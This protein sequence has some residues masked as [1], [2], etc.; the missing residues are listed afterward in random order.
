[1]H[2]APS[3]TDFTVAGPGGLRIEG[4]VPLA[5]G[6]NVSNA[7]AAIAAAEHVTARFPA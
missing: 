4:G 2:P 3:R 6:Y 7:L 5:G 1:M